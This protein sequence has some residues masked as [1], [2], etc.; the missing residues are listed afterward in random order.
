MDH[1]TDR[2]IY[3]TLFVKPVVN[4]WLELKIGLVYQASWPSASIV[5]PSA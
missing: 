1:P 2:A 3:I 5:K 4:H